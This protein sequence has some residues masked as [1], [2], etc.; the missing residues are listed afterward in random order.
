MLAPILTALIAL[1]VS[2][3][4]NSNPPDDFSSE[5]ASHAVQGTCVLY[6]LATGS[7]T[8]HR[9]DRWDSS[10]LPASTF[11]ILNSLIAL[12]TGAIADEHTVIRWDSVERSVAAWNRDLEMTS[13]F[14]VSAVWF[15]QELARRIG[16]GRMQKYLNSVR[17]G[18][19]T[20]GGAIDEFWLNG[21][22]RITP[23]Q[24]VEFL[25]RLYRGELPFSPSAMA[26][27]REMMVLE[28]SDRYTLRGKTG[29]AD[30]DSP[31]VGWFVGYVE[32]GDRVMFFATEIDMTSVKDAPARA[33][34]TRAILRKRGLM[35]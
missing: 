9:P 25:V 2:L 31:G 6:D 15:Y 33:G 28:R 10:Y 23:R 17:Y 3:P 24:Q 19:G 12:E 1:I 34:V 11:K 7:Y 32:R 8:G 22:L 27:V 13:A 4:G 30:V 21:G 18:N 16:S 26:S 20:M 5:F 29:W 14:R 35:D